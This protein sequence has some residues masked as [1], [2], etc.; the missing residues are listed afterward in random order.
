[1]CPRCLTCRLGARAAPGGAT[2]PWSYRQLLIPTW[3]SHTGRDTIC[4]L[5]L[6]KWLPVSGT[7]TSAAWT[8]ETIRLYMEPTPPR[9]QAP[10]F[11]VTSGY[12][13]L[14]RCA[15]A[16]L[17]GT[18]LPPFL[19]GSSLQPFFLFPQSS[20]LHWE[21]QGGRVARSLITPHLRQS[22]TCPSQVGRRMIDSVIQRGRDLPDSDGP[23]GQLRAV[24]STL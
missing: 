17:R 22:V 1:M 11:S 13:R 2:L 24:V 7:R 23:R 16:S 19:N 3:D 20:L 6:V 12:A 21:R 10:S 18:C 4:V 9:H 14:P 15:V 8:M 5:P